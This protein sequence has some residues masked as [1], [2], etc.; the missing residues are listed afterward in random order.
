MA[1][2]YGWTDE[3]IEGLDAQTFYSYYM[4]S[5]VL[6]KQNQLNLISASV[7]SMQKPTDIKKKTDRLRNDIKSSFEVEISEANAKYLAEE[8][9]KNGK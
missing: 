2:Y 4:S 6:E 5:R 1:F 8:M 3:Y 9:L 7:S